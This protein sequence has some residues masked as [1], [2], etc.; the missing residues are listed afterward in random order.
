MHV[1]RTECSIFLTDNVVIFFRSNLDC[2]GSS[3]YKKSLECSIKKFKNTYKPSKNDVEKHS[4]VEKKKK[5]TS[6]L[7]ERNKLDKEKDVH[8]CEICGMNFDRKSKLISHMFKHSNLKP[9][10]CNICLKVFK[11]NTYLSKHM[12]IHD[13]SSQYYSCS[14]CDFQARSKSYLKVHYIRKHTQEYKFNCVQ[15]GKMFKVQ[16]DYTTHMKD[17]DMESCVCDICGGSYSN[18]SSLYFHKHYKH[19]STIK[20]FE[21]STCKKRFK[22]QKNLNSHI[23][24]HNMKYVCEQCGMEFSFKYGLTKHL[25][26]HSGEKLYLCA[27]CGKTFSCLSSQKIHLLKHAGERPYVCDICG[28]SFTQRSPMMLHRKK[29]PGVHPPPPPI[30]ITSLLHGVQEKITTSKKTKE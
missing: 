21:C 8:K 7:I 9:Y 10:K 20:E 25:R 27:I 4:S 14:V 28:Q 24:L 18:K 17:H 22:N 15:C 6:R 29:H 1:S 3:L 2:L 23:E 12:E 26:T 19:V 16:S 13:E 5:L 11:T 30:K